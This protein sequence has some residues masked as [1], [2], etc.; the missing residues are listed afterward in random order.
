MTVRLVLEA[1][2]LAATANTGQHASPNRRARLCG[3]I[4]AF[5]VQQALFRSFKPADLG[6]YCFATRATVRALARFC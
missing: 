6:W 4:I 3:C 2:I 5:F 1:G